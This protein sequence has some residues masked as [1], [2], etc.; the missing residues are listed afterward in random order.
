[1]AQKY[2]NKIVTEIQ[3]PVWNLYRYFQ[4]FWIFFIRAIHGF[5]SENQNIRLHFFLSILEI[6]FME[7]KLYSCTIFQKNWEKIQFIKYTKKSEIFKYNRSVTRC[8]GP[9]LWKYWLK[10]KKYN[11]ILFHANKIVFVIHYSQSNCKRLMGRSN[12]T[13]KKIH[14][15]VFSKNNNKLKR[16]SFMNF[17]SSIEQLNFIHNLLLKLEKRVSCVLPPCYTI[18]HHHYHLT[19][20]I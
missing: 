5:S 11:N 15:I 9:G 18:H 16:N 10:S 7:D 17:I 2:F 4:S 6:F 12:P 8:N 19:P 3:L 14:N 20:K 13:L 1:M